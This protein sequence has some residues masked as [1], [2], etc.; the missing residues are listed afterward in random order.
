M[1]DKRYKKGCGPSCIGCWKN[2]LKHA[3]PVAKRYLKKHQFADWEIVGDGDEDPKK[4]RMDRVVEKELLVKE[5]QRA[6]KLERRALK[7]LAMV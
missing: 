3:N 2:R 5:R 4:T 1:P 7:K 6:Q